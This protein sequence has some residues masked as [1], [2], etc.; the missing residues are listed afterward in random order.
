MGAA[1]EILYEDG[2]VIGLPASGAAGPARVRVRLVAGDHCEGC[3]AAGVCRPERGD[4]ARVLDVLDPL[5]VALGDRVR[6][7]VP[8]GA[9]MR[10]SFLV[11][12]LPMLLLLAGV[13]LGFRLWPVGNPLRDLLSF[14]LGAGLAAAG[15]PLVAWLSRRAEASGGRL[16]EP[17]IAEKLSVL[18]DLDGEP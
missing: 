4:E 15:L 6:V 10:A 9:V 17:R 3:P 11:Y 13:A 18:V 8:G 1:R 16:L 7:A 5:G 12:G 2:L 14:L